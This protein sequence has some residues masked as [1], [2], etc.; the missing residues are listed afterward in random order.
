MKTCTKC[1]KAKCL[2]EFRLRNLQS[3]TLRSR[4]RKCLSEIGSAYNRSRPAQTRLNRKNSYA[5]H[6]L[7]FKRRYSYM[8]SRFRNKVSLS[9]EEFVRFLTDNPKCF[10]CN[11]LNLSSG[12]GLDR[13]DN[14]LGYALGNVLSCCG[15]CNKH[16]QGTWSVEEAKIAI[17]A[18]RRYRLSSS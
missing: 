18:V 11:E 12:S 13:I 14:S 17:D 9:L 8:K 6:K 5:K 3:T 1:L 4:C 16:R 2:S 15:D 7:A 10:Y